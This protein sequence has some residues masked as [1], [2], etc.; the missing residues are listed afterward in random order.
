[1]GYL[2]KN[3]QVLEI[4]SGNGLKVGSSSMKCLKSSLVNQAA[5]EHDVEGQGNVNLSFAD[6][7]DELVDHVDKSV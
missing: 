7:F 5:Y 4:C 2:D 1:M 3:F 6:D